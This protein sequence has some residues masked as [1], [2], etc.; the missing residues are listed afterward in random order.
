MELCLVAE[1]LSYLYANLP[2]MMTGAISID[3]IP[4]S[5]LGGLILSNDS[6]NQLLYKYGDVKNSTKVTHS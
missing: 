4:Y 3:Y 6:S 1:W 5:L 2:F